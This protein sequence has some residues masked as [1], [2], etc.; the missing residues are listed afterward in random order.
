MRSKNILSIVAFITAF[1][2]SAAFASL[3]IT[4]TET[5][6]DYVPV[7]GYNST[8]CFKYKNNLATA[9]K[10]SALI[11]Q[12]KRNGRESDRAYY[13]YGADIFSSSDNTAFS[14]YAGA[15]EQYVNQSSSMKAD[16]LPNDFQIEWRE[17]MKA[18]REYSDFLNRMKKPSNRGALTQEELEEIDVFHSREI[19]RTWNEVLQTAVM[20]GANNVY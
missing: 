13:R 19:T 12:D 17:H 1:A 2:L 15:V 5:T 11:R 6:Y 14:G 3:F 20:Y 4:K 7:N 10:I 8:S 9:N 16:D 18:W